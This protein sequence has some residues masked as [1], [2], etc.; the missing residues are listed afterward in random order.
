[1]SEEIQEKDEASPEEI[2]EVVQKVIEITQPHYVSVAK[3]SNG[4]KVFINGVRFRQSTEIILDVENRLREL[5]AVHHHGDP[6]QAE[7]TRCARNG[8]SMEVEVKFPDH[9]HEVF[10]EFSK[11]TGVAHLTFQMKPDQA[12]KLRA[13]FGVL[14]KI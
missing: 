8:S 12:N 5:T 9:L 10:S 1:M 7:L 4:I 6:G 14:E 2:A 11:F 13:V 3:S